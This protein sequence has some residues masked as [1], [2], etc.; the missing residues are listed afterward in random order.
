MCKRLLVWSSIAVLLSALFVTAVPRHV[1]A[2]GNTYYVDAASG[3]DASGNGSSG[4]PWKTISK[5]AS[6]VTAGDTVKIRSGTYR[7]TVTPANS[8]T[9]GNPITFEPDTNANVTVSGAEPVS[10]PWTVHSGSIYKTS[11]NLQMGEYLNSVYVDGVANFLARSPN[12]PVG[13]LYDPYMYTVEYPGTDNSGI[14]DTVNLTQP[15][16]TWDNA[17][18]FI[19]DS[20][21]WGFG[22]ALG[23][24]YS[25]GHL[26]LKNWQNAYNLKLSSYDNSLQLIGPSGSVLGSYSLTVQTNTTYNLKVNATGNAFNVYLNNGSSPVISVTDYAQVEGSFGLGV[27]SDS[28]ATAATAQ[29][30]NVN[31]VIA[32]RNPNQPTGRL[33]PNFTSNIDGWTHEEGAGFWTEDGTTLTGYTQP[34]MST[35]NTWYYSN[36]TAKDFTY[37]ADVTLT[38]ASGGNVYLQ[39]R[40][41]DTPRNVYDISY[42]DY[43][44]NPNSLDMGTPEYYIMGSLA[45]LDYPGEWF[46]DRASG[47]LYLRTTA[48][49]TPA[50]HTVEFKARNLAFDLSGKSNIT[51][52]GVNLFAA[53]IDTAN[54][55]GNVI[56]GIHAKYLSEF[57]K[58]V[59]YS[60]GICLCGT[61]NTLM[62]SDLQYSSGELVTM[63]GT[64]NKLINNKIHDGTYGP[65]TYVSSVQ[66]LGSG[67]LISHNEVYHSGRSLIGGDFYASVIQ[68]NDFHDGNY[69]GTDTGLLY[70]AHN[71]LGNSEIHHN[72]W[73]GSGYRYN[74]ANG[75]QGGWDAG[76]YID[77]HTSDVLIYD[78]VTWDI[79]W[80]G[81]VVNHMAANVLVY[82]NTT[83]DQSIVNINLYNPDAEGYGIRT[84]NNISLDGF[85][86]SATAYG[87][88]FYNN[89]TS[90]A[91]GY[92][93]AAAADF[94]L[95]A[96]SDAIDIGT[97]IRGITTGYTGAAPDAGAYE[98]GGT[99]WT[100]GANLTNPPSPLPTYQLVDTD[101]KNLLVNGR[102]ALNRIQLA[103]M[104]SL[105]GWTKTDSMTAQPA[106]DLSG[107]RLSSHYQYETGISLGT[108][109]DGIEQTITGLQPNTTYELRGFLRTNSGS[110]SVRLGVKNY[111]G[112][113]TYQATSSTSWV[114]ETFTFTTGSSSTSATI[115]GYKPTTGDY[116]FVDDVSVV[117]TTAV[118][119]G[120]GSGSSGYAENFEST[121]V[122]SMPSG[123]TVDTS[124]GAASVQQVADGGNPSNHALTLTQSSYGAAGV[125]AATSFGAATGTATVQFRMM[126]DQTNALTN[127]NLMD[128]GGATVVQLGFMQNGKIGYIDASLGWLD[129]SV[130]YSANQWYDVQVTVNLSAGTYDVSINGTNALSNKSVVNTAGD[131]SQILFG[132]NLW[133]TGS[134]HYDN[135]QVGTPGIYDENFESTSIGSMPSGWSVDTSGGAASVQQVADGAHTTN[136]A[137]TLTQSSYGV[138]DVTADKTFTSATGTLTA[139]V[140]MKADQTNSLIYYSL[141]DS[142][143]ATMVQLGFGQNG[144]FAYVDPSLGWVDTSLSYSA[145]QWYD[146][147]IELNLTAGTYDA[148]INGSAVLS[149]KPLI[150]AA[151][152]MSQIHIGT[153]MWFMGTAHFDNIQ[154]TQ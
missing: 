67:H 124:G 76:I 39:F 71:G 130:T 74:G 45:A 90:G 93:N 111:G 63:K 148:S 58:A 121:S 20:Y 55:T 98:Y 115:Y 150:N 56:D 72:Y 12:T 5:A 95:Q 142:G 100:A 6:V 146:V 19:R 144:K 36:S 152:D 103:S 38:S 133:F 42:N 89:M 15:N 40:K 28:S 87:S 132:T 119:G 112:P 116:A 60:T 81:I 143:G 125:S 29:F 102:L 126:A 68:Y 94:R 80:Y 83:Y 85:N 24:V 108:G 138:A 61:N 123:W 128:S 139:D 84:A 70:V 106:F 59:S 26:N 66:I 91:P 113:D 120:S 18:V 46:Y 118:S 117:A 4:S 64:N 44:M 25:T 107:G 78:N 145:S 32:S 21:G 9:V 3:N 101:Y 22:G 49:D 140:R 48:S 41:E 51:V 147:Q 17:S 7:E 75:V 52:K 149:N 86:T 11:A 47:T 82:N 154:I 1:S 96:G 27:E 129:T 62:N 14:T 65:I 16:G 127:V 35:T 69:F 57:N 43:Y 8:G 31:A 105:F 10:G 79:P 110:Q 109:A 54:G 73:H 23:T 2:A 104:D 97:P 141:N 13:N 99:D 30:T 135:I 88:L 114:E 53:T 34:S 134:A 33:A 77:E 92:V 136:H 50:N 137:L 151:S 37:S 122:G 131:L 153:N